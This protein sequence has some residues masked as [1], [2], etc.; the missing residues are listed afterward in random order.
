MKAYQIVDA[1]FVKREIGRMPIVDA[2]S[3]THL[4]SFQGGEYLWVALVLVVVCC[5]T[6]VLSGGNLVEL[7][8]VSIQEAPEVTDRSAFD[9]QQAREEYLNHKC[10]RIAAQ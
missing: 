4:Y 1:D 7:T 6:V 10:E 5:A 9:L 2:V 8:Q 3:Y